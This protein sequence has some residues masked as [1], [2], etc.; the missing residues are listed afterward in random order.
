V[1]AL[2]N[3][4]SQ[5]LETIRVSGKFQIDKKRYAMLLWIDPVKYLRSRIGSERCIE[6]TVVELAL[7]GKP[8][9][10]NTEL[11]VK[12]LETLLPE[13]FNNIIIRPEGEKVVRLSD[14]G[15]AKALDQKMKPK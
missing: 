12:P 8:T 1:T 14:V 3:V 2:E 5:R 13:E 10:D 9:G 4:I 11:T 6:Q 7:L 15:L